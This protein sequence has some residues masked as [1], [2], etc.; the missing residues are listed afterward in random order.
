MHLRYPYRVCPMLGQRAALARTFGCARVVHNDALAA[1]REARKAGQPYPRSTDLQKLVITEAKK[2]PER[3]WLASV[4][5]D[6]LIQSLRDLDTAYRNFFDSV[7]G[8]RA[9]RPVG[10]PGFKSRK[11]C[12]TKSLP[13][14]GSTG[15]EE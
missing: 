1:R 15:R 12:D 10:L 6:P 9:G 13:I 7:S 11:E 2:T 14:S 8:K 3:A 5:V 4:G